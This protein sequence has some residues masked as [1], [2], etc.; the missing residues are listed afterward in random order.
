MTAGAGLVG[1]VGAG[2]GAGVVTGSGEAEGAAAEDWA[3]TEEMERR[4]MRAMVRRDW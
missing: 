2:A 3:E 1:L 4:E